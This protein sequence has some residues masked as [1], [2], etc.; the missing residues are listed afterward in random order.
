MPKVIL[1]GFILV[2]D[3][4][5]ERVKR[6]LPKHEKLTLEESGCLVF[7]VTPD[8]VNRNKFNVYEEFVSRMAFDHHQARVRSSIW[9]EVTQG[10]ERH[11]QI[12]EEVSV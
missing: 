3:S 12:S 5:L 8:L 2:P 10:V 4:D 6:E 9:G 7:M 1:Q 11:Y